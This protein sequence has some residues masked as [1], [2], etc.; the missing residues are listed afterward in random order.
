MIQNKIIRKIAELKENSITAQDYEMAFK[1][2][3]ME[4]SFTDGKYTIEPTE[5]NFK[6]EITKIIEY[7]YEM[8]IKSSLVR[9]LKLVLLLEF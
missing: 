3:D 4:K 9:D 1:L 7:F 6:K 5:D 8:N 2:R